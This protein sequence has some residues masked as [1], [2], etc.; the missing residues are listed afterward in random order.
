[1]MEEKSN[2]SKNFM[3]DTLYVLTIADCCFLQMVPIKEMTDCLKVVRETAV[4]KPKSWVRLKRGIY[5]DDLAQV[6]YVESAQNAVHLKMLPRIDYTRP[7]GMLRNAQSVS[8]FSQLLSYIAKICNRLQV[9]LCIDCIKTH[10]VDHIY[11]F[12]LKNMKIYC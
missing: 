10:T 4:L 1:M 3:T 8:T 11:H 9:K 12:S 6:D 2:K 7:R 5:K